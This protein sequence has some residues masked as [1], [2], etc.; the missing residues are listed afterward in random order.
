MPDA[1]PTP[2]MR[3]EDDPGWAAY[4]ETIL[5]FPGPALLDIDLAIPVPPAA[6]SEFAARGLAGP[7]GLVTPCNPRGRRSSPGENEARLVRFLAELDRLGTRY[8][9]VD[10]FSP[11]RRHVEHGVAL[12]WSQEEIVALARRWQQS[13]V[14]WWDG[15]SFWVIGALTTAEPWQLGNPPP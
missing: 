4:A 3:P 9:R 5:R 13:A 14:Y 8:L 2:T 12:A 7:F 15:A 11:D 1:G 10:G 6:R